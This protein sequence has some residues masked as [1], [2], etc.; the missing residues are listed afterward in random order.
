M[1]SVRVD[2]A[3]YNSSCENA[4]REVISLDEKESKR[5]YKA[6][7]VIIASREYAVITSATWMKSSGIS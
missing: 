1:P 7:S 3:G 5:Q 2:T 4:V 6:I